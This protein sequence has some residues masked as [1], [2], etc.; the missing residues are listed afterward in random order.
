MH[1]RELLAQH[2]NVLGLVQVVR[3]VISDLLLEYIED[4]SIA[5]PVEQVIKAYPRLC[6]LRAVDEVLPLRRSLSANPS[7]VEG[8]RALR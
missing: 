1:E 8:P 3:R 5:P 7:S 4:R 6:V 2:L